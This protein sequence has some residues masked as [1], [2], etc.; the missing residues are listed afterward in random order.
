[1]MVGFEGKGVGD[2]STEGHS[3]N[4]GS[5]RDLHRLLEKGQ[6]VGLEVEEK[7]CGAGKMTIGKRDRFGVRVYERGR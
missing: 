4:S 2:P 6:V 5:Y 7:T 3:I 1:M